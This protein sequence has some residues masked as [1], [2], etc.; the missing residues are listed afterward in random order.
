MAPTS[1]ETFALAYTVRDG[2]RYYEGG[3]QLWWQAIYG[4]RSF[5]VQAG[6]GECRG[7]PPRSSRVGCI[8]EQGRGLAR[9]PRDRLGFTSWRAGARS[10]I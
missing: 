1:S 5:P 2:L 10:R 6:T 7:P 4:D 8:H 9:R 3:D